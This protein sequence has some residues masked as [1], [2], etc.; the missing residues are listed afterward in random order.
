MAGA[1]LKRI[2]LG[3]RG[4]AL[5]RAQADLAAEALRKAW[6]EIEIAVRIIATRG[7]ERLAEPID[8]Q[9]GR[10]G[11]FTREIERALVDRE[12][13]VAVHSAKDL[14]SQTLPDL[15]IAAALPRSLVED[16][17]ITKAPN[18]ESWREGDVIATGSVRRQ[19][20]LQWRFPGVETVG[21]RGNVPTRLRKFI[22]SDWSAMVLAAAG[23][24]RLGHVAT[25]GGF[26]F[27]GVGLHVRTLPVEEFIPAG[28]QGIIALQ[29]RGNDE[30]IEAVRAVSDYPTYVCLGAEREFLRL[31]E[32][33]CGSPVGVLATLNRDRMMMRA[34]VFE[35]P[36]IEPRI[37]QVE[38]GES[39]GK[40]LAMELLRGIN[41]E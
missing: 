17:I 37:A 11:L 5:A 8:R 16:V 24:R 1:P 34:Q 31:L 25:S 23:L 14:P 33:D 40:K 7:D 27:E 19:Y 39:D 12:I 36:R 30:A 35:P 28:G 41:G 38:G 20:Q 18:V 9:A 6:P 4:S 22:E 3:S 29:T 13:D 10:K 26:D 32:G 2:V 15:A 21:I